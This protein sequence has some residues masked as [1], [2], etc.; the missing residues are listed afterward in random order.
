MPTATAAATAQAGPTPTPLPDPSTWKLAWAEEFNGPAGALPGTSPWIHDLG[1]GSANGLA[2]WGNNELETYTASTANTALDG[3]GHLLLT[4][5]RADGSEHCYYGPC[6]YTSARLTTRGTRQFTYGRIEA[7]IRVPAGTGLWPAF[8]MLGDNLPTVGWPACGEIDV[9]ET[10]GRS[11]SLVY[12]TIHGPGYSGSSSVGGVD[13]LTAAASDS[14]HVFAVEWQPARIAWSVDGAVYQ[15][16]TPADVAPNPWVFDHS[17][18][19]LLNVAVGGSFGG[20]V[21]SDTRFPAAMAVDYVR[22][23]QP[24]P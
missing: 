22:V 5:R 14:F 17:F 8:W 6:L 19:L 24:V 13:V 23:Y 1:D 10:V 9:V 4:V 18:H 15:V 11:P 20:S 3:K 16:A 12:G 21:S 7:R 2:G